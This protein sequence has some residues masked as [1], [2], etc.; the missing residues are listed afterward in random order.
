MEEKNH[1][2]IKA[3][4]ILTSINAGG[5]EVL[6]LDI[7][8]NAKK[9]SLDLSVA[10]IGQGNLLQ[11]FR[12][13]NSKFIYYPRKFPID[14]KIIF[15]LRKIIKKEQINIVH[16]HSELGG[17]YAYISTF[18]L[19]VKK[20]L[21]FHGY[22][23]NFISYYMIKYLISKMDRNIFVSKAFL[24][25]LIKSFKINTPKNFEVIYNG[26]SINRLKSKEK[27]QDIRKELGL[28]KNHILMGMVGHFEFKK[29]QYTICKA[30]PNIFK[31]NHL[32][33]F[34]FIGSRSKIN[35]EVFDKCRNYCIKNTISDKVF[36]LGN[37]KDIHLILN[38][39]DTFVFSSNRDTFGIALIEAML[40]GV[41]CIASDIPALIEITNNG[42]SAY[43]FKAGDSN[44]LE[45]KINKLIK[46]NNLEVKSKVNSSK[47]W[48]LGNFSI[49]K[50]INNLTK[51]Y[52]RLLKE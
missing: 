2:K 51:L 40:M 50:H 6:V 7:L 47:K 1:L 36:F 29:D 17:F 32:A 33:R 42:K 11:E 22:E 34:V 38:S 28:S 12:K 49:E 16:A 21:S 39:L 41:P 37:R 26:V 43:L 52:N 24:K 44:D 15:K 14:I 46:K 25:Y 35:P 5:M 18:G 45:A 10:S 9:E 13:N 48:A 19:K 31:K 23:P 3:L 30:L 27:K 8:K 4:H 20:V